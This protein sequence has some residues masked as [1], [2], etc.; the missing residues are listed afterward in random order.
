[1]DHARPDEAKRYLGLLIE[2]KPDTSALAEVHKE[3]GTAFFLRLMRYAP[4]APEAIQFARDTIAAADQAARDPARIRSLIQDLNSPSDGIRQLALKGL[5]AAGTNSINPIVQALADR[6]RA[7]EHEAIRDGLS[8]LGSFT[9]EPLIGVLQSS[10]MALVA[11]IIEVLGRL[12]ARN[13]VVYMI[14]PYA[15]EGS[16]DPLRQSAGDALVRIV[17]AKPTQRESREFLFRRAQA[18]FDG[19]VPRQPGIDGRVELWQWDETEK[20]TKP[21]KFTPRAAS[22]IVAARLSGDLYALDSENEE[23]KQLYIASLLESS[24][25]ANGLDKPLPQSFIRSV[26][27]SVAELE[28]SLARTMKNDHVPAAIAAAEVL[29]YTADPSLLDSND[30]LPRSLALALRHPD[31]RLQFAAASAIM[32]L[33]PE[34]GFPGSSHFV[35]VLT[36]LVGTAGVRRVLIGD[37]RSEQSRTLVGLLAGAGIEADTAATGRRFFQLASTNPDYEFVLL[38]DAVDFPHYKETFQMLRRD[39]RTASLPVGLIARVENLREVRYFADLYTLAKVFP[40]PYEIDTVSYEAQQLVQIAGDNIIA[41]TEKIAQASECLDSLIRIASDRERYG[42]YDVIC[43]QEHIMI[44]LNTPELSDRTSQLL[45]LLGTV[46]AQRALVEVASQNA[47]PLAERQA[48]A[49]AFDAAVKNRGTLLTTNQ[50]NQQYERYNQS[51]RLDA[52][53][54]AVL[55]SILDTIEAKRTLQDEERRRSNPSS[56]VPAEN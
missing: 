52:E 5:V 37:P 26:E 38:S 32:R 54:Q 24:K 7:S 44:A 4:L 2:S 45:G 50:I 22:L 16:S 29:G 12:D 42:F 8:R 43:H 19:R 48:A 28:E 1:M 15:A 39:P 40:W 53:T 31:R 47:R 23:Y 25:L 36:R 49:G 34:H 21:Q 27:F 46:E 35:S 9:I 41:P 14:Q 56:S 6:G 55:S 30:G 13:A 18:F 3:F 11:H 17:G 20:A 10:D 51:E 33:D